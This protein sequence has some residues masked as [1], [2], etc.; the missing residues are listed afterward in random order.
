MDTALYDAMNNSFVDA[1]AS[2]KGFLQL[3]AFQT[4]ARSIGMIGATI[5]IFSRIW[6]PIAMGEPINFFPLMRPFVL[7]IAIIFSQPLCNS[8]ERIFGEVDRVST[9][10]A[11]MRNARARLDGAILAREKRYLKLV[12]MREKLQADKYTNAFKNENGELNPGAVLNP[13]GTLG[14][15]FVENMADDAIDGLQEMVTK[16]MVY[17]FDGAGLV[18]YFLITLISMFLT[19]I[20]AFVAPLAFAFAIFDGYTNNAA[21]WFAKYINAK[22]MILLCKAYTIFTYYFEIPFVE[23]SLEWETG[24]TALYIIVVLVCLVGYFFVPT[25]A[26]MAL[27]VGGVGPTATT[28]SQ[29][30]IAMKNLATNTV[31]APARMLGKLF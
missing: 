3:G 1:Y 2:S 20:L 13:V 11:H 31:T 17:I 15:V 25:M 21:E 22:L 18:G 6:G 4:A 14:G 28:A 12:E 5:Y 16:M 19:N 9:L 7:L 29:R 8:L 27:S 10:N 30:V 23:N 24:R 26:N